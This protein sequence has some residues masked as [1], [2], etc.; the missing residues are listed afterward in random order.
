M[1]LG[2]AS[3]ASFAS[4]VKQN[5]EVLNA[6]KKN[7]LKSPFYLMTLRVLKKSTQFFK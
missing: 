3:N 6:W 2:G 7:N 1:R 5:K 4:V